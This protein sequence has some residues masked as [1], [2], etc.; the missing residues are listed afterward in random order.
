[1]KHQVLLGLGWAADAVRK[2]AFVTL[3]VVIA[4][5]I[6]AFVAGC[7]ATCAVADVVHSG[8]VLIRYH[9]RDGREREL[10]L[11]HEEADEL[12]REVATRRGDAGAPP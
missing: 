1:M 5:Y 6:A 10:R 8:C 11:S 9:D 3:A 7:T 12:A 2:W 4:F